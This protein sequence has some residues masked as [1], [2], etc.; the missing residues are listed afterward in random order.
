MDEECFE[1]RRADHREATPCED[2]SLPLYE[3]IRKAHAV[4]LITVMSFSF[5]VVK[6]FV[7]TS[8]VTGE[9]TFG[10]F[11]DIDWLISL[12]SARRS[13]HLPGDDPPE[14]SWPWPV[15][16]WQASN[17]SCTYGFHP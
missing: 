17:S 14:R 11:G 4:V 12:K 2:A 3:P 7:S 10:I 15:L 8:F 1:A 5:A 16:L 13:I 6:L 9:N